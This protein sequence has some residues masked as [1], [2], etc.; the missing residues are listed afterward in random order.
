MGYNYDFDVAALIFLAVGT[1]CLLLKPRLSQKAGKCLLVLVTLGYLFDICDIFCAWILNHPDVMEIRWKNL[2]GVFYF[3]LIIY[4]PCAFLAYVRAVTEVK[5]RHAIFCYIPAWI[6]IILLFFGNSRWHFYF[7]FTSHEYRLGDQI[8]LIYVNWAFY[9]LVMLIYIL[10]RRRK[11]GRIKIAVTLLLTVMAVI[12]A[13]IQIL[14]PY[15]LVTGIG[16]SI[17]IISF[18]LAYHFLDNSQDRL[19]GLSGKNGFCRETAALLAEHKSTHYLLLRYDVHHFRDINERCGWKVGDLFLQRMSELLVQLVGDN[20]TCGYLG[21]DDFV[22]CVPAEQMCKCPFRVE[23]GKFLGMEDIR[24]EVS[25]YFGVY[26]IRVHGLDVSFMC[27]RAEYALNQIKNNYLR[28][29]SYFDNAMELEMLDERLLEHEMFDA[30]RQNQFQVY[31]Q[32]VFEL[33]TKKMISAEALVRWKHPDR[34]LIAP[35]KFIPLFERNGFI[36]ELDLFIMEQV[37]RQIAE[38][39][40]KGKRVAPISV[41]VSRQDFHNR[42]LCDTVL[43]QI[44]KYGLS[45][46]DLKLEVTESAFTEN[47]GQIVGCINKFRAA[48]FKI[49]MDDFGS[50]YSSFNT[51]QNMPVDI[52][53]L[54]MKFLKGGTESRRGQIVLQ[55]IVNMAKALN[56]PTIAEGVETFS[57]IEYL[58]KLGCEAVQGY[59]YAKPMPVGEFEKKLSQH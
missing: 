19:T 10:R 8:W 11:L 16:I 39:K 27:D 32:P 9:I 21:A 59:Y 2:L 33:A 34:G 29:Y 17:G 4:F 45:T 1:L 6:N 23:I 43:E 57:E 46:S 55:C 56:I 31:Y 53:K 28:H 24:Q 50:G 25:F 48:G 47:F 52:L 7:Q 44:R 36:S 15:V 42:N 14:L 30:L 49:L 54:D 40:T 3:L 51:F 22:F 20:G 12:T 26:D 58:K 37:C 38:W 35:D 5:S 18:V 41:N 13:V